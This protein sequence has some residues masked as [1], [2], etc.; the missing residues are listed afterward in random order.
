[1]RNL[2]LQMWLRFFVGA[3]LG[4]MAVLAPYLNAQQPTF[5]RVK[6][7][8]VPEYYDPPHQN[9]VKSLLAGA[10]AQPQVNGKFFIKEL[11]LETYRENGEREVVVVS[12]E[13]VFDSAKRV[14]S[15]ASR[16]EVRTGD[17]QFSIEGAGFLWRQTNSSLIISNNVHTTIRLQL[18][19][20]EP[21]KL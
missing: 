8:S 14:A 18:R 3:L 20:A 16:L 19:K 1:M 12:P 15:S 11:K 5:G 13:C 6:N 10:E 2:A 9:Q 21:P 7:F 17:G 4:E